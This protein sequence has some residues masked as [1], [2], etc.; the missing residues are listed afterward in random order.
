MAAHLTK[1]KCIGVLRSVVYPTECTGLTVC[2]GM[3]VK[4]MGTLEVSL[5]KVKHLL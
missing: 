1:I 5:W 2:C 3:A 4:R